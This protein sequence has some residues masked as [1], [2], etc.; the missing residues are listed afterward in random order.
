MSTTGL[1]GHDGCHFA[2][3]NGYRNLGE[4]NKRES[5][6]AIETDILRDNLAARGYS[7][8]HIA[9]A[10]QKRRRIRLWGGASESRRYNR[11]ATTAK[12]VQMIGWMT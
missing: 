9:A 2:Y 8:A 7:A 11:H 10:L 6:R 1:D 12:V 5:N 4:W 3:E